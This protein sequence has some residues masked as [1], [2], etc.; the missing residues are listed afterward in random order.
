M[1]TQESAEA[2]LKAEG[3]VFQF[4]SGTAYNCWT[5][6]D[7]TGTIKVLVFPDGRVKHTH[8]NHK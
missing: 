3:F 6:E 5:K 4:A 1:D 7:S 8:T 2:R